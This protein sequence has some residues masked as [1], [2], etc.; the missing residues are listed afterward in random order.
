[1]ELYVRQSYL[2]ILATIPSVVHTQ[3]ASL[4]LPKWFSCYFLVDVDFLHEQEA[5]ILR[6]RRATTA[7]PNEGEYLVVPQNRP[8]LILFLARLWRP[9]YQE[10]LDD[11]LL[12]V[13][14]ELFVGYLLSKFNYHFS[15]D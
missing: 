14:V 8:N 11:M 2:K 1:M 13:N 9:A 5:F 3:V 6:K 10:A 12:K 4:R 7:E 15:P